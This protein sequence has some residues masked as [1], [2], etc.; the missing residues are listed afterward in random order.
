MF[1]KNLLVLLAC[2]LVLTACTKET[3][4]TYTP[5]PMEETWTVKMTQSGGI[6][7]LLRSIEVD[8]EGKYFVADERAGETVSGDLS[9]DEITQL[10]RLI[11]DLVFTPSV[12]PAICADCFIYDIE[13]NSGGKKMIVNVD[14]IS[15]PDSGM[16]PLVEFLRGIMD[17]ALK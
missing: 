2:V 13:I 9:G 11:T 6:M 8:S 17:S 7:G 10:Q 5:P 1:K 15:L 12:N 14:D 16:E 3:G 4:V